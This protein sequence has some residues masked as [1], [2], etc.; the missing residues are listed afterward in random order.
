MRF[1]WVC[2]YIAV[3]CWLSTSCQIE[4]FALS[5]SCWTP[6]EGSTRLHGL[7]IVESARDKNRSRR[8]DVERKK[9]GTD[10]PIHA[11]LCPLSC[12]QKFLRKTK[13]LGFDFVTCFE[14]GLWLH[15]GNFLPS[16]HYIFSYPYFCNNSHKNFRMNNISS[17]TQLDTGFQKTTLHGVEQWTGLRHSETFKF[18]LLCSRIQILLP[19]KNVTDQPILSHYK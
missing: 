7:L 14:N 13:C 10:I 19:L 11:C 15:Y 2:T 16:Q 17:G 8:L 4:Q 18:K 9:I 6:I 12:S 5:I 3:M 1:I